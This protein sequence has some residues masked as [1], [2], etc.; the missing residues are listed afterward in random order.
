[1]QLRFETILPFIKIDIIFVV[2]DG[3]WSIQHHYNWY[4]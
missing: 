2:A 1:L 3:K 4:E